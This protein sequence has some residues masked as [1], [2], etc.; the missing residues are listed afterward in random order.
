MF[1]LRIQLAI[2]RSQPDGVQQLFAYRV[3]F[4]LV[5]DSDGGVEY[6]IDWTVIG[7]AQ[8]CTVVVF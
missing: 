2:A 5:D 6:S 1:N 3:S 7:S 8:V 4:N